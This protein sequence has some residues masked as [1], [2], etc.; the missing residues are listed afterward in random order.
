MEEDDQWTHPDPAVDAAWAVEIRRR[1][2]AVRAGKMRTIS[3][4]Q[5]LEEA[6]R[7]LTDDEGVPNH[8]DR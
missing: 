4:E 1:I 5:A 6:D 8:P 2:R 7:L 3:L